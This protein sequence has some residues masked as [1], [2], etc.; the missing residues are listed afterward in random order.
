MNERIKKGK[1][2]YSR[3]FYNNKFCNN[4]IRLNLYDDKFKEECGIFGIYSPHEKNQYEAN[5]EIAVKKVGA[6]TYY[7]LCALQHRGEESA[8]IVVSD[9]NDLVFHKGMGLV[10]DVFDKQIL[11]K[12]VG[13]SAIGHVRYSTTGVSTINNAQPIVAESK[14]GKIAIAHN[15]NLI[16][17]SI[18]KELMEDSGVIFQTDS[19]S[20]VLL[21]L[22]AKN[23]SRG[24]EKAVL[25]AILAVK[26][27]F[28]IVV[29]TKDKLI[30]A[31]DPNGIRPL[32]LGKVR[33][34]YVVASETCAL[35]AIGGE[36][37]RDILPSE[38][39]II[40]E[41]GLK[42][43]SLYEKTNLMTCAF[44]YIYFARP[45]S[46]LDGI[47]VYK[48]RIEA[49]KQ[50]YREN[51][52]DADIVVGIPD[53][54]IA[55]AIGYS[56]ESGI[57]NSIG[58]I[59]SKYVG[60]TFINPQQQIREEKVSVKLNPLKVNVENKRVL[61][62]DDSIVRGTTSKRLV[63]M[64][65]NSGAK[66]VHL[67]IASPVVKFPCYFGIDTPLRSELIGATKT[68]SQIREEIGCDSLSYLSI[69]GLLKS[70]GKDKG[71]CLGCF[72]GIYPQ[73]ATY[74]DLVLFENI[75][76]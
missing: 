27:S 44:E 70:L 51:K 11:E 50:L 9:G 76:S 45:D 53:S 35:D 39:V 28:A 4:K 41:N 49:G 36:F 37:I 12:M 23:L 29:L 22:I 65:R 7:G 34:S 59:K 75:D 72:E 25:D 13:F 60:R 33:G 6:I 16:N 62:I 71:F 15:G 55:A 26:G 14:V 30:A 58:F 40:D 74:N 61:L 3:R 21:N 57:S 31:R 2:F 54:G 24:L 64:M 1:L 32:C 8:G 43:I 52:V 63:E 48:T 18:L 56:E 69:D 66:E 19:D 42:S 47:S 5:D 20:E 73:S 67:A 38:I 68:I 10:S 17:A 46:F